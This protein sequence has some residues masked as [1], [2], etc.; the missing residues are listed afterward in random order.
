MQKKISVDRISYNCNLY[1]D[2]AYFVAK[3]LVQNWI[4]A[5]NFVERNGGRFLPILQ[6]VAYLSELAP[7]QRLLV[8]NNPAL[9]KQYEIVYNVIRKLAS[10]AN[11][12]FFDATQILDDEIDVYIDFCH[13]NP[14]GNQKVAKSI[15][16]FLSDSVTKRDL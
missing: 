3:N 8:A 15:D 13:L 5:K 2:K 9:E 11:L 14:V 12:V 1:E 4:T 7:A 10:E 16:Y 6:P